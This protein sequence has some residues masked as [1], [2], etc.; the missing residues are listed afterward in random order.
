MQAYIGV[1]HQKAGCCSASSAAISWPGFLKYRR[2][3]LLHNDGCRIQP[4]RR[5]E[6]FLGG[7]NWVPRALFSFALFSG[8]IQSGIMMGISYLL[9]DLTL[10]FRLCKT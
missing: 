3:T 4:Q 8:K 7:L 2:S 5:V 9:S 6:P 1:F 10:K